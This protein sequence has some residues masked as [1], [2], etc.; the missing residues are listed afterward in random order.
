MKP[1][2]KVDNLDF[3]IMTYFGYFSKR[4]ETRNFN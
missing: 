1:K 3:Q 4:T 2:N